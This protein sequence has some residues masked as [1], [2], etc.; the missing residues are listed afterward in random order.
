MIGGWREQSSRSS[1]S[2]SDE[3]EAKDEDEQWILLSFWD[4]VEDHAAFAD[5]EGFGEYAK[6]RAWVGEFAVRHVRV[7]R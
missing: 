5:S 1:P 7:G 2:G 4:R 3:V 6:I